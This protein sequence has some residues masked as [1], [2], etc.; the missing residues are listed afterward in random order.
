LC[1]T[2][3]SWYVRVPYNSAGYQEPRTGNGYAGEA[4]F[5]PYEQ[6]REYISVKLKS[7]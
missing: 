2:S 1:T 3:T 4:V 6:G 5:S 7:P